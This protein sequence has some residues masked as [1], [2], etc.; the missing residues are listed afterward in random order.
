VTPPG[1]STGFV[2]PDGQ[3][4]AAFSAALGHRRYPVAGGSDRPIPGLSFHDQIVRWSTDGKALIVG[5]ATSPTVDRVDVATGRREPLVTL[6]NRTPGG[7]WR[8]IF[9][10]MADD[11]DVYA[12]VGATY[13]SE[14]FTVD[15][16]R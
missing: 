14:I 1:T 9:F 8:F 13:L 11:P 16:V 15:G 2:S 12:Y 4:V 7:S 5:G 3:E 10:A 6:G